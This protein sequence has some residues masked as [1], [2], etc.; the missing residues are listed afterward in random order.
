MKIFEFKIDRITDLQDARFCAAEELSF[1][2]FKYDSKIHKTYKEIFEWLSGPKIILQINPA[3]INE[4]TNLIPEI[5]KDCNPDFVQ[6][7][8]QKELPENLIEF[9]DKIILE[10]LDEANFNENLNPAY[11]QFS[12]TELLEKSAQNNSNLFEKSFLSINNFEQKLNHSVLGVTLQENIFDEDGFLDFEKFSAF[13]EFI[14]ENFPI[15]HF[16]KE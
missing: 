6:I 14:L 13:K 15:K 11:Y 16:I 8:S 3:Q 4:N 1:I 5:I 2:T 9:Q 12:N 10:I 7:K